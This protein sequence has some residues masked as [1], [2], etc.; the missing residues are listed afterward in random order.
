MRSE[1]KTM[2]GVQQINNQNQPQQMVISIAIS[3]T[4][5]LGGS[6]GAQPFAG[7]A[8]GGFGAQASAGFGA[9]SGLGGFQGQGGC[10]CSPNM[11]AVANNFGGP[12]NAFQAGYQQG[13]RAGRQAA[14]KQ[15][16][17]R[18]LAMLLKQLGGMGGCG[19]GP[20]PLGQVPGLPFGGPGAVPSFGRLF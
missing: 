1:E 15:K 11:G 18:K 8:A 9:P 13:M 10:G 4:Q 6:G 7:A 3:L 2:G 12:Q 16:M 20:S 19:C 17:M 5:G 14:K